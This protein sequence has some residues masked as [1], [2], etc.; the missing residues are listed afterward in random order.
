V[1][2]QLLLLLLLLLLVQLCMLLLWCHHETSSADTSSSC[3][4]RVWSCD[5]VLQAAAMNSCSS[6]HGRSTLSSSST[7]SSR[8]KPAQ[9][10]PSSS[11]SAAAVGKALGA[12]VAMSTFAASAS[13][14]PR[15]QPS[16]KCT[17]HIK[18]HAGVHCCRLLPSNK[19]SM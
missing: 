14:P 13:A 17:S 2:W 8:P 6:S 16:C 1:G 7:F 11:R 18:P 12:A 15:W 19:V 3:G 10:L 9:L 4:V 5:F